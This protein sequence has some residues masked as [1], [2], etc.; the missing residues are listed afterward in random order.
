MDEKDARI[1][2]RLME[3]GR[4][5]VTELSDE[6]NVPRAT[7]QERV[8]KMVKGGIIKKFSAMPDYSKIGRGVTAYVL[9]SFTGSGNISQRELAEE[10]AKI[11]EVYEISLVSGEWDMLLKVRGS[12]V[13]EIGRLV[14][15]RLRMM[16]GIEK[17]QT[18][19]SF[20]AIKEVP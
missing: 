14:I 7:V 20:Q 11:P 16:R 8:K 3:D 10:M 2:A 4:I 19:L 6:L 17:T 1:L 9:V 15:D 13:E 18:C 5:S 12:S